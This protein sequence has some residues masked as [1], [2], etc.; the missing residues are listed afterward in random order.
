MLLPSL[1]TP[2]QAGVGL[3]DSLRTPLSLATRWECNIVPLNLTSPA[4]KFH[5]FIHSFIHLFILLFIQSVERFL[6]VTTDFGEIEM[7]RHGPFW[8]GRRKAGVRKADALT[9]GALR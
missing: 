6:S 3:V 5:S 2:L 7:S 4:Q 9:T 8:G 1:E